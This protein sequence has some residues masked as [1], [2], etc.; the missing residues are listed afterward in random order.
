MM[1]LTEILAAIDY[2]WSQSRATMDWLKLEDVLVAILRDKTADDSVKVRLCKEAIDAFTRRGH[3]V[4][5]K[6][7]HGR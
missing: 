1:L 5:G 3:F 2:Q 7:A 6:E 4:E